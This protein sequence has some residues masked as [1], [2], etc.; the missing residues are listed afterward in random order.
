MS[1]VQKHDRFMTSVRQLYLAVVIATA[2]LFP[3]VLGPTASVIL[4]V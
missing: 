2:I 4:N 3:K 1:Y